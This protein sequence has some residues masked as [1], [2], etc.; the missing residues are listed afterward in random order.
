MASVTQTSTT[1]HVP[2]ATTIAR[3]LNG[4][5]A[6]RA[7]RAN[8]TR[9]LYEL[10]TYSDRQLQDLWLLGRGDFEAIAAGTFRDRR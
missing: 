2:G 9:I 3:M 10:S 5:A 4:F 8:R 6:R 1:W 7:A